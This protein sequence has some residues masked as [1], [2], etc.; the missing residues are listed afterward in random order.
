MS[1]KTTKRKIRSVA[2]AA[3]M[4]VGFALGGAAAAQAVSENVGDTIQTGTVYQY[5]TLRTT[6]RPSQATQTPVAGTQGGAPWSSACA[7]RR[8]GCSS[9]VRSRDME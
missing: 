7:A 2:I 5:W 8:L 9:P 1:I 3:V 4:A 6:T